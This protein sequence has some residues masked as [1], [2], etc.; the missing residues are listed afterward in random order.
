MAEL[1]I[2]KILQR[3][4]IMKL[5]L[6]LETIYNMVPYSVTADVG[7]DHGKLM[8]A[9]FNDGRIPKGYAIENKQGPYSRLVKALEE[10]TIIDKVVP[11]LS[12]GISELPPS[13][14]T[15]VLA[16]IGGET[17]ID[18]ISKNIKNLKNV[19]TIII[20]AH[21]S[22]P[23][24]RKYISDLGYVIADEKIIKEDNI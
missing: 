1:V 10:A 7:S 15:I 11:M 24:L 16:G 9:L 19:N 23:K 6:R 14:E 20:D 2:T 22:T 3:T 8:I 17:I 5:S 13:V 12:D 21:T 18:I 4:N